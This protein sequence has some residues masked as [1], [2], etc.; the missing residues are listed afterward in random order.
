[1]IKIIVQVTKVIVAVIL[2]IIIQ[3][4]GDNYDFDRD[5]ISG[6]KN[7]TSV[8]RNINGIFTSIEAKNGLDVIIEQGNTTIIQVDADDNLHSHIFTEIK[9]NVLIVYTDANFVKTK[10]QKVY[11][12]LPEIS[13]IKSSSGATVKSVNEL[14]CKT[15][16]LDSSSGSEMSVF[17]NTN[18]L[19]CE[20]SSGSEIIVSGIT[21]DLTCD[22]SSGSE[23][24]LT[25]LVATNA[26][27]SSSSGSSIIL[28]VTNQ[29]TAEAS[30][31]SS[32]E[33]LSKP[34]AL[35]KDESSGGR[36]DLK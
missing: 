24:N 32:I 27:A 12:Q 11:I 33:Y 16:R 7:V 14:K 30:S 8:K 22:T 20:S 2:A 18:K 15:L 19:N 3:S 21:N 25:K 23:I 31:G 17:V 1:M 6:N 26:K 10:L 28:N 36:I 34:K 35:T 5:T 9:D 13:S 4:C 29:L